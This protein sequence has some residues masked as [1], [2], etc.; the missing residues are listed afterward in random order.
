MFLS[1]KVPFECFQA[2]ELL[3]IMHVRWN[4]NPHSSSDRWNQTCFS[5]QRNIWNFLGVGIFLLAWFT[6]SILAMV[7]RSL[8][9]WNN[10][11]KTL[12]LL[13]GVGVWKKHGSFLRN[14]TGARR[15]VEAA[16]KFSVWNSIFV[17]RPL[18]TEKCISLSLSVS[19]CISFSFYP[20][21]TMVFLM[22]WEEFGNGCSSHPLSMIFHKF[23][24]NLK[25]GYL[26]SSSCFINDFLMFWE[27]SESKSGSSSHPFSNDFAHINMLQ[28]EECTSFFLMLF[29]WFSTQFWEEL[30]IRKWL[31]LSSF[32]RWF[33]SCFAATWRMYFFLPHVFLSWLS[34]CFENSSESESGCSSH[35]FG[36]F[37]VTFWEEFWI[38]STVYEI[39]FFLMV[40][41]GMADKDGIGDCKGREI[42]A[43]SCGGS[44]Q[45]SSFE[46]HS[47]H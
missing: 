44:L 13:V 35:P 21:S 36:M 32:F 45:P 41:L 15:E 1:L 6:P 29:Q 8:G 24:G 11:E 4:R 40:D 5:L 37:F 43:C 2:L 39:W 26:S 25:N 33:W 10:W 12:M 18:Q 34:P 28:L 31:L 19:L 46:T 23:C 16:D 30:W 20:F 9:T 7:L 47:W 27:D 38:S 22:F 17:S 3:E 14:H 42:E